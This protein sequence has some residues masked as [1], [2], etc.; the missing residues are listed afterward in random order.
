MGAVT[1]DTAGKIEA[2]RQASSQHPEPNVR[3]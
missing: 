2:A 3:S 1:S